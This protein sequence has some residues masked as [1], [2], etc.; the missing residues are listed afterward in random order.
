MGGRRSVLLIIAAALVPLLLFA[1]FQFGFA[2]REQRRAV[3]GRALALSQLLISQAEGKAGRIEVL[4][5]SLAT[6]RAV[7]DGDWP[8]LRKRFQGFVHLYPDL[9]GITVTDLARGQTLLS[10]GVA[11]TNAIFVADA[12]TTGRPLFVGYARSSECR[13]MLFEQSSQT[14]G[15]KRIILSV[16]TDS[17]VFR[18]MLPR[19]DA[20][21]AAVAINGPE[22]RFIA[23]SIDH[24]R[25]FGALS[26]TYLQQAVLS[27]AASGIYR[28]HTLEGVENYTAFARS[29]R[30]GWT[31]HVALGATYIDDPARRYLA[32]LG[33][34]ALLSL[35][36]AGLLIAFA[37]RQMR[38]ARVLAERM[39]QAQKLEA[40]GQLTGGLAH[41]FNNLLTPVVGTLDL[42]SR[43]DSLDERSRRL[44]RGA[45]SSAQ[46]AAKLTSQLLA[47][48]RRQKL[49]VVPVPVQQLIA[50]LTDLIERSLGARHPFHVIVDPTVRCVA[51]DPNQLEVALLNLALNA[52]DASSQD[53]P[54]TLSVRTDGS[55][56]VLFEMRDRGHGMDEQ[57]RRRAFE[58]FFTTKPV[59]QGTG[60][61]LA[62]VFGVVSQSGGSMSIDSA[63]GQGTTVTLRFAECKDEDAADIS[64]TMSKDLLKSLRLLV[65]DD[66]PAARATIAGLLAEDGHAVES[67]A[68]GTSALA[69]LR[70]N[71]FDLV[72]ADFQMPEMTGAELIK[73]AQKLSRSPR[74]LLISGFSD[75]EEIAAASPMTAVLRKPFTIDELRS[76]VSGAVAT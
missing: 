51:S 47:F 64:A 59:G 46:R 7:A 37:I 40:L 44:A 45:L 18:K 10:L 50:S 54:V 39:Q 8:A 32:S 9:R 66:D 14:N 25:R 56:H 35:L 71:D 19:P 58:P 29:A 21:Y 74:F 17:D 27:G 61:G 60:L 3:E 55:G 24:E 2:A 31:A 30:T 28:G 23:R 52:R 48:S 1:I 38:A 6:S 68:G 69:L 41:D 33:G 65:V 63:P 72:V 42:L 49:E 70:E 15:G 36:L 12:R 76:A 67:V 73:A 53:S 13:C 5:A 16:L 57:T 75:S 34:A 4:L 20:Q 26:S 43:R 11:P 62:Q 22:A